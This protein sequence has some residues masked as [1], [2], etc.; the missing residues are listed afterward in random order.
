VALTAKK[1]LVE[2]DLPVITR[3]EDARVGMVAHA[4][5]FKIMENRLLVEFFN[6]V[7]GSIPQKE[8]R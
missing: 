7:K 6:N 1:T 5:I 3:V 8:A 2:S 4:V